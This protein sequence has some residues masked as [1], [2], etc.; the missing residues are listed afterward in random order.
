[1]SVAIT[2]VS[3]WSS[4]DA[5]Y[6]ADWFE[7][8]NTGAEPVDLAGWKV[9]DSSNDIASAALLSGVSTLAPGG[10]AV[11][12]EGSDGDAPAIIAEFLTAWTG[13]AVAPVGFLIGNYSGSGLGLS[14]G[15][16]AVNVFDA[17]G[18]NVASVTF[19]ASSIG[20]TFDNTAGATGAISSLSVEGVN[21]A[22]VAADG[23]GVGSP[24]NLSVVPVDVLDYNPVGPVRVFDTRVGESPDA[25]RSVAKRQV[26]GVVV[27]EVQLTDL[28]GFVPAR[29]VGAVSL[30]LTATG[31]SAAGFITVYACGTRELVSSVNFGAGETVANAVITPLSAAGTV[32]VFA[33]TPVDVVADVNGWFAAGRAFEAVGPVRVF[34]TRAGESPEAVRV[35]PVG[36][37]VG[38]GVLEVQ[39]TDLAGLVPAVGVG[40]VSLNVTVSNPAG[41]GFVTVYSCGAREFV[42]SVNFVTGQTVPNAVIAPVSAAG[43][44]CFFSTA[45]TD[46]V[47]DINGW[48]QAGSGFTAVSPKRVFDTRTGQS[49]DAMVDVVEQQVGGAR[50]LEVDVSGLAGVT[51]AGGV[52]AVSINVTATG[53]TEPGFVTV[54]ACGTRELVSS[55]NFAAGQTVANAVLAPVSGAGTICFFSNTPV[56]IVADI[57]GWFTR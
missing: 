27:L 20:V 36:R 14:T 33:N 52:G 41:S 3:P 17:T 53:S 35:V 32:C 7:L 18:T 47:V 21:G 11:F 16:D 44:V 48:L 46:L 51:P 5:P 23:H 6:G 45:A 9:D 13:S 55:V 57:N 31:S 29:G 22:F 56:D 50:V 19:G 26:G 54:Y 38:G 25:L 49:P 10:S 1:M 8:T 34:D 40:A 43:T 15:G 12:F 30:N 28:V 37:V 4:G 24:A 42:S 39:V 2:E